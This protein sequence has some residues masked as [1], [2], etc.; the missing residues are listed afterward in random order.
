MS[1]I[2]EEYEKFAMGK[3]EF[4]LE[5]IEL[6]QPELTYDVNWLPEFVRV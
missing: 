5:F 3:S 4:D 6:W 2:F 1:G